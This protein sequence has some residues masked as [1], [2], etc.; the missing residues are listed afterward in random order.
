[1]NENCSVLIVWQEIPEDIRFFSVPRETYEE[2]NDEFNFDEAN[3]RLVNFSDTE[4]GLLHLC[5][6]IYP[7]KTDDDLPDHLIGCLKQYEIEIV[8]A[9][10]F[11]GSWAKVVVS[12]FVL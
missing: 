7:D 9:S 12:G 6:A 3:G 5:S 8:D 4:G 11:K 10:P 1:M 2:L